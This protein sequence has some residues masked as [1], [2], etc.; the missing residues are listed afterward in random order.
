LEYGS[1]GAGLQNGVINLR[2]VPTFDQVDVDDHKVYPNTAIGNTIFLADMKA[3]EDY[4]RELESTSQKL[5]SKI[6][7][8]WNHEVK[9]T[10]LPNAGYEELRKD[11]NLLG[12]WN[13]TQHL[14]FT[15]ANGVLLPAMPLKVPSITTR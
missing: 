6:I 12:I 1:A 13:L 4:N 10:M 3:A 15:E 11:R 14:I 9:D 5:L 8:S 7:K 2:A